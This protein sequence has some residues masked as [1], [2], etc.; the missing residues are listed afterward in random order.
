MTWGRSFY[1][2][3]AEEF[4][5]FCTR[6]YLEKQCQS[7][8]WNS[9]LL[10]TSPLPWTSSTPTGELFVAFIKPKSSLKCAPVCHLTVNDNFTYP[11]HL[12]RTGKTDWSFTRMQIISS[13]CGAQKCCSPLR[14][15]APREGDSGWSKVLAEYIFLQWEFSH[16]P[17]RSISFN[18]HQFW[19]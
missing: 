12:G 7:R 13:T 17:S 1:T 2:C 5:H 14:R 11:D 15:L 4:R 10:V 9:T 18:S 19:C 6:S 8:C 3:S 16:S